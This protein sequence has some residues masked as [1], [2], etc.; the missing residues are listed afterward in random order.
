MQ[1]MERIESDI[2]TGAYQA[3]DL[4]ISTTQISKV[5]SVNPTTAVKAVSKLTDAGI[6]YKD[7]G[8]GMRV[9]PGARE[10]IAER[11][12]AVF[13]NQTVGALLDEAKT[14]GISVGEIV[15]IIKDR[16]ENRSEGVNE[17]RSEDRSEGMNGSRN[18][19]RSWDRDEERSEKGAHSDD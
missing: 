6:L 8:I 18:E 4:I 10:R 5:Y 14:L 3:G 12:R 13:L 17:D 1:I 16:N 11:R 19:D 2:I 9:A 15:A 7:R